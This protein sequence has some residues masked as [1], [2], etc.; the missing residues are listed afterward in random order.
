MKQNLNPH[1]SAY[2]IYFSIIYRSVY[3]LRAVLYIRFIH[4]FILTKFAAPLQ[5]KQFIGFY[6]KYDD[7]LT[8]SYDVIIVVKQQC[9]MIFTFI[10][11]KLIRIRN[12]YHP[13][14]LF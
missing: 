1:Y 6:K 8:F 13:P 5:C 3:F 10:L 11:H 2:N 14:F 4:T 12:L 9:F 7:L